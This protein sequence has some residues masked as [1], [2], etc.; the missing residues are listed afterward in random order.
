MNQ[1][2]EVTTEDVMRTAF[3][4]YSMSVITDRALPDVRDG[5]K[6]VHRRILHAMNELGNYHNKPFKK[7]ARIVGDVIGKYH[8]HGDTAVYDAMVRMA[9]DFS[10]SKLLVDGQGNFGSIDGDSPAAMRYTESRMSRLAGEFFTDINKETIPWIFNYDGSEK[11]PSVL[12]APYP[13]LLV[14]GVEGI[15]VG[16]ASSIPPHNFT[17]VIKATIALMQNPELTNREFGDILK[18]PDFPT[19]ALVYNIGGFYEAVEK[20]SGRVKLRSKW[21]KEERN[22]QGAESLIITEIP[23]QVNK[24]NVLEK[25]SDLVKDGI[26]EGIVGLR[27]ESN[28]DG[29]RVVVEIKKGFDLDMVFSTL[30]A[31]TDLE[32]SVSYN[33][34]LI[35]NGRPVKIGLKEIAQKWIAFRK[36]VVLRRYVFERKKL[37]NKAEILEGFLAAIN[38]LDETISLIRGS[39]NG[40][41]ALA[42]IMGLLSLNER[43]AQ[44]ILDLKLQKLTGLELR[45]IEE[46][47]QSVMAAIE[48]LTIKIES[49]E[50][51]QSDIIEELNNLISTYG[52]ERKTEISHS[53]ENIEQEDLIPREEVVISITRGGY[54]KR[55]PVSALKS[56]KR[57]TRGRM[58]LS[59][60]ED[61]DLSLVAQVNSHDLLLVFDEDGRVY[62]TKAYQ[63]PNGSF[64]DKGRHV[65][66]ILFG[67]EREI[68]AIVVAPEEGA[69]VLTV[70]SNGMVK[71]TPAEQYSG[72]TRKGGVQGVGLAE[73]DKIVG[74]HTPSDSD[75]IILTG[76]NGKAIRFDVNSVR[77]TGRISSGVIGIRLPEGEKVVGSYCFNPEN[78]EKEDLFVAGEN[79]IGKKTALSSY[80]LQGRSGQGVKTFN[81]T[82]KTGPLVAALGI[83]DNFDLIMFTSKGV[84]NKISVEDVSRTGRATS[85]VI[86]LNLDEGSRLTTV[87]KSIRD[88]SVA[89][90]EIEE[91]V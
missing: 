86:L 42:G 64:S 71:K 90:D 27:D 89:F 18:A 53:V 85:G 30:A 78:E 79:G 7:S 34:T 59:T 74:V 24:A 20:G 17:D 16:M 39:E 23:Y 62:G 49:P 84:T 76:T 91:E 25:I 61:D 44:A 29:I 69:N 22:K 8:P 52:Q 14:N 48:A 68:A 46:D 3:I 36:A 41:L 35:D 81:I 9:Q 63:I 82:K 67:F 72:A 32:T 37:L 65:R 77:G 70:T 50:I 19:G 1:I 12:T 43:Q 31:K 56:Q 33:C 47:Y 80:P 73:G 75:H 66:N 11:E 28:K 83:S 88:E 54:V 6:P 38:R 10:M 40:K 21:H 58:G 57:G 51:I 60:Y 2:I 55:M 5:L 45:S 87:T 4:N 13:N 15:A 26:I